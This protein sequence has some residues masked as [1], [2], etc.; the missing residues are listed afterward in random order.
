MPAYRSLL[1]S[2]RKA[3]PQPVS[4]PVHD[5]YVV[6]S[7]LRAL[8]QVDALKSKRP[9]L[10]APLSPQYAAARGERV[11]E[12]GQSLEEVIPQLVHYLQG[13]FIWGHPRAQINVVPNPTI[14]SL[15]GMLLPLSYNPNLCSDESGR[16]FSEAEV[17]ASAMT[18]ELV[19]YP[20]GD[21]RGVFTFGGTGGLLYGIKVGLEKA[22]PG[23]A[24]RRSPRGPWCWPRPRAIIRA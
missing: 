5:G 7:I 12:A 22:Q 14:A 4:D 21:A 6:F 15:I 20:P 11:H 17:R 19:G 10:G 23:S 8:D 16:L 3:F 18:A 2:L 13:M 24:L 9:M 1:D